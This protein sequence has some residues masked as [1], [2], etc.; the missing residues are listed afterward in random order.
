MQQ[1]N[2]CRLCGDR[3]ETINHIISGCSKLAL[4]E[5]KARHVWV[6]KVIHW[7]MCKKFKFDHA[8]KW[9]MHNPAS[10]LEN[11]THKVLWDFDIQ[12]DHLI[13]ATR[14]DLIIINKKKKEMKICKIVDFA[15]P[16]DHRIKLKEYEK[17]DKYL[18]LAIELKKLWNMKMTIIPIVSGAFGT[19]TKGLKGLED[20]DVGGRVETIQT[21]ALLKTARILRRILEI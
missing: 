12:T 5:C 7:E 16:A 13:S 8:N 6:G 11:D 14:P 20:L 19:V 9:Y 1:N 3:G 10:V 17:R 2:K 15:V 18:D 4:K 21:T